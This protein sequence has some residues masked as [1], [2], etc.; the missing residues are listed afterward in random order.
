MAV[1]G[2]GQAGMKSGISRFY[3]WVVYIILWGMV[4]AYPVFSVVIAVMRDGGDFMWDGVLRTWGEILPFFVLFL[5]HRLPLYLLL[6]CHRTRAYCISVICLIGLFA[7]CH[8]IGVE[9]SRPHPPAEERLMRPPGAEEER[10]MPL[11][12]EFHDGQPPGFDGQERPDDHLPPGR[13]GLRPAPFDAPGL[14]ILDLVIAVLMLGFDLAIVLLWR[15]QQEQ[16]RRRSMEAVNL[17]HELEHLKSQINPHF[18][19]NMLNN[20]HGMVEINP[21]EAQVMIMELSKL[22]RY[23]L[24]EG[25]KPYTTLADEM[26]FIDNYVNL[27]RKRYSSR[28]VCI[29]LNL[30]E[31][32]HGDVRLP[33]LLFISIIEN[34]FKHGISY[35]TS[36]FVELSLHVGDGNIRL[37]CCNSVHRGQDVQTGNEGGIGLANLRQRLQLLYGEN[38]SLKIEETESTYNVILTVPIEYETDTLPGRG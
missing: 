28:K 9:N 26:D 31:E 2:I 14:L 3:I 10:L 25:A 19:M 23:V 22:M 5:L 37:E 17:H 11:P 38:F 6:M 24:Y 1:G 21:P 32:R 18:F 13:K 34:A 20:I 12:G 29:A 4:W 16:E 35:K 7:A 8:H 36:S 27:M 30:P 15:Y 33:P